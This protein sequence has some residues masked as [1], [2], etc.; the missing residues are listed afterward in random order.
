MSTPPPLPPLDREHVERMTPSYTPS[1]VNTQNLHLQTWNDLLSQV[2]ISSD[3]LDK[4]IDVLKKLQESTQLQ[5]GLLEAS[6]QYQQVQESQ[7]QRAQVIID[8][9]K[10]LQE[11]ISSLGPERQRA[12]QILAAAQSLEREWVDVEAEMYRSIQPF[13][14]AA[15]QQKLDYAI[16][17]SESLSETLGASFLEG[18][19]VKKDAEAGGVA[20]FLKSYRAER[21]LYHL[22]KERQARWREERVRFA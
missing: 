20:E 4:R 17:E 14:L 18:T 21:K 19:T 15:L 11:E 1:P 2:T 10:A 3:I 6:P 5:I 16:N 8:R 13:S 7:K 12:Q 22:R 9:A